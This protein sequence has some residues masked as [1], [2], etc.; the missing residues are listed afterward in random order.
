MEVYLTVDSLIEMDDIMI[1]SNNITLR[2][3]NVNPHE[4]DKMYKDKKL[5]EDTFYQITD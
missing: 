2:K 5:I 3:F 1:S 4:F